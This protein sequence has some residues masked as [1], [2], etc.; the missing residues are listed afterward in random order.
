MV[1]KVQGGC[2]NNPTKRDGQKGR[3]GQKCEMCHRPYS[4]PAQFIYPFAGKKKYRNGFKALVGHLYKNTDLFDS[5]WS[6][7]VREWRNLGWIPTKAT[8]SEK[9]QH[10]ARVAQRIIK[11]LSEYEANGGVGDPRRHTDTVSN[12][13]SRRVKPGTTNFIGGFESLQLIHDGGAIEIQNDNPPTAAK[14][15]IP[16]DCLVRDCP[17]LDVNGMYTKDT[18]ESRS[19]R[20]NMNVH[21]FKKGE[22]TL[23]YAYCE[24]W[25]AGSWTLRKLGQSVGTTSKHRFEKMG[26]DAQPVAITNVDDCSPP[27][28]RRT[29]SKI[30]VTAVGSFMVTDCGMPGANG[31]YTKKAT[32]EPG[33]FVYANEDES[34]ILGYNQTRKVWTLGLCRYIDGEWTRL[35]TN[36]ESRYNN[37]DGEWTATFGSTDNYKKNPPRVFVTASSI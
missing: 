19:G 3:D 32:D 31:Y 13:P 27:R 18:K 5:W 17:I 20:S 22:W 21:V 24:N 14:K 1:I 15:S 28:V 29:P 23:T 25:S 30:R 34:I 35:G 37:I 7:N 10:M 11:R 16:I 36:F 4:N 26:P 2:C 6:H 9:G 12:R 8:P 33:Q